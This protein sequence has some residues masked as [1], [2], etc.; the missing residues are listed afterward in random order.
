MTVLQLCEIQAEKGVQIRVSSV[1]EIGPSQ[2]RHVL[3]VAAFAV[4]VQI[5]TA[6]M[7]AQVPVERR[8]DVVELMKKGYQLV[9][10]ILV[11]KTGQA[12]RYYIEHF[13]IAQEIALH[14]VERAAPTAVELT[15]AK[16]QGRHPGLKAVRPGTA[17]LR[18]RE[19]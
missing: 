12:K 8:A 6:G 7:A 14:L 3:V 10:E 18:H 1:T 5:A 2:V 4:R 16:P 19:E 13:P 11:Q 17:G 9:V 15:V